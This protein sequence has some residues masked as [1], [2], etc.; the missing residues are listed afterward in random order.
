MKRRLL[1]GAASLLIRLLVATLRVEVI[2]RGGVV[3]Q[4]DHAPV[5]LAFWHNRL[6][7]LAPFYERYCRGRVALA[8][9][10]RSRDGQFISDV[11]ACFGVRSARGSTSRAGAAAALTAVH[12]AE[13]PRLEICVTPDGPRGP[14]YEVQPG[15]LRLAQ[16]T[17]R[18]IVAVTYHLKWKKTLRSWDRFQVPLPFSRCQLVT[19]TPI[20]VPPTATESELA[21]LGQQLAVALGG[22]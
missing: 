17:G 16:A 7:L 15:V 10:S 14:R 9:I 2:D 18:P 12:A 22:D 4:P 5:I 1:A 21:T 8:M 20:T 19:E 6:F 13:D 11:A 3:N